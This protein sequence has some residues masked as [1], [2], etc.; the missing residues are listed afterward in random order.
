MTPL[1]T[2]GPACA[3]GAPTT[4]AQPSMLGTERTR[5][6]R[7]L[8]DSA[9]REGRLGVVP[10]ALHHGHQAIGAL[11]GEMLLEMQQPEYMRRVDAD[12]VLSRL[13]G[14]EREENRDQATHD[15]GV[16]VPDEAQSRA[17]AIRIDF[18][19]EP[20]L[21]HAALHLVR[22]PALALAQGL[23]PAPAL[24]DAAIA[25]LP[26]VEELEVG[27][28]L[29]ESRDLARIGKRI[30]DS[31]IGRNGR[32]CDRHRAGVATSA[33]RA[34]RE[35]KGITF[36]DA[37]PR[38]A[39][40]PPNS[41]RCPRPYVPE[42]SGPDQSASRSAG[43]S[44][45]CDAPVSQLAGAA[46]LWPSEPVLGQVAPG[47]S[48][49]PWLR[50]LMKFIRRCAPNSAFCMNTSMTSRPLA[51]GSGFRSQKP[52]TSFTAASAV[53]YTSLRCLSSLGSNRIRI[54]SQKTARI[55]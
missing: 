20:D 33:W 53:P 22:C 32:G 7:S 27:A 37:R 24:D 23:T 43:I 5:T 34:I 10:D 51:Q 30:H 35:G 13:A 48:L 15:M 17:A 11:W 6:K 14:V 55:R 45:S 52:D 4:T 8:M 47:S 50:S 19:R 28:D 44:V 41:C 39:G 49:P 42:A 25:V 38:Q 1:S 31:N 2:R 29:V 54:I 18:G 9:L 21:A 12:D 3:I 16:A 40:G 46:A 36:S 26:V